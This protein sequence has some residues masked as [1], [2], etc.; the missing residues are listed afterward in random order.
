MKKVIYIVVCLFLLLGCQ[1]ED[2]QEVSSTLD[3]IEYSELESYFE[4]FQCGDIINIENTH[5]LS[6]LAIP[7]RWKHSLIYLGSKNQVEQIISKECQYYQK[8]M[9][10]YK[11]GD[12]ILVFDA[13]STGV[14]IR[15]FKDMA[16]LKKES[17]LKALACYRLKKDH[18][19]IQ[20]FIE[21][22]MDYYNTPYDFE[23]NT[24][25]DNALY[26]SELIYRALS[27]NNIELNQ[28]SKVLDYQVITPTDLA[29][30][31][32]KKNIADEILLL[33][34]D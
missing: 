10:S 32:I 26:C 17:Y 34:N 8:I 28:F 16:N 6:N 30:E 12:E 25:D 33:E 21:K 14:K 27:K 2:T 11:D 1:Q 15:T 18:L 3:T 19:F 29:D 20:S 9:D 31:L 22:A 13:N 7:G 4:E 23:M 5:Y 24:N